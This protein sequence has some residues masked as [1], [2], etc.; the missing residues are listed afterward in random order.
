M[1]ILLTGGTGYIGSAV[2]EALVAHGLE[3]V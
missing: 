3:V 2:L 1:R